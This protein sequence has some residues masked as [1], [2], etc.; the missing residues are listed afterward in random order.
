MK[1]VTT[2]SKAVA[3]LK[4]DGKVNLKGFIISTDN[5]ADGPNLFVEKHHS[6][7]S[8][9]A[10]LDTHTLEGW[11]DESQESIFLGNVSVNMFEALAKEAERFN[12]Y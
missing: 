1:K 4:K 7:A 9:T 2:V 11:D 8:L 10:L 6:S 12:L 3:A 5:A